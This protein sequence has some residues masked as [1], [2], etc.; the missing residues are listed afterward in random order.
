MARKQI[1]LSGGREEGDG[2]AIGGLFGLVR[3]LPSLFMARVVDREAL[4]RVFIRVDRWAKPADIVARVALTGAA[5]VVGAA[6]VAT[7]TGSG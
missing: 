5:A 6:A 7:M 3:A 4:R 1:R 2:L